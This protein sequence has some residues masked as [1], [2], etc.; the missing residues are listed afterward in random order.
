VRPF[1]RAEEQMTDPVQPLS[2]KEM[3]DGPPPFL[4]AWKRVYMVVLIYL[5]AVI[6]ALYVFTI[7]N[8][9]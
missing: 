6:C 4:G 8:T 1:P 2:Q 7:I 3:V 9:P 5:A